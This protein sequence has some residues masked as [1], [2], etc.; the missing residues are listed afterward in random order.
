MSQHVRIL[1]KL[2]KANET[3]RLAHFTEVKS[4][5]VYKI[6]IAIIWEIILRVNTY[7]AIF[8]SF[9]RHSLHN[10]SRS[11]CLFVFIGE[12]KDSLN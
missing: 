7:T 1:V 5:L 3:P 6:K 4:L 9:Y 10:N 8:H 2:R 12:K 11:M